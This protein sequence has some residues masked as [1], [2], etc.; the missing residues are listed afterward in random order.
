MLVLAQVGKVSVADEKV[1]GKAA[2]GT[3]GAK[4]EAGAGDAKD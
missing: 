3:N 2:P 1:E 4:K